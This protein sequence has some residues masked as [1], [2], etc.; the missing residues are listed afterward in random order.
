MPHVS[1]A[2]L[3]DSRQRDLY[4]AKRLAG[5][6]LRAR[7]AD[8][9]S[10]ATGLMTGQARTV[11]R[12][13]TPRDPARPIVVYAGIL[14]EPYDFLRDP[15]VRVVSGFFGPVERMA[16]AAGLAV[17]FFPADFHGFEQLTLATLRPRAIA[18]LMSAPDAEGFCTFGL[19]AGATARPFL[20]AARDPTRLAIAE[21]NADVPRV[22]GLPEFGGNRVHLSEIDVIV[23]DTMPL[24]TV[25]YAEPVAEER[26]IAGFVGELVEAGAT[27]QFGIGGIPNAVA[28]LLCAAPAGDYGIHTEM[29]VDGIMR[30]H[31]AGK[32]VNRKG[33]LDGWSLCTFA[34]GG[35]ELYRW[36]DRNPVVRMVPVSVT[37]DPAHMALNRRFTSINAALA[38]DLH[39]QVV[40]DS[41]AGRQYSGIG[42]HE[43]FTMGARQAPGGKSIVCLRSTVTIAGERRSTIVAEHPAGTLVTTPRHQVDYVVTEWG[44]AHLAV[45]G[46][47]ARAAALTAIAHPDFRANLAHYRS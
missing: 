33:Y 14:A 27:L 40:A 22:A 5:E 12:A 30:L 1:A 2:A 42:G 31:Q 8:V 9:E 6:D 37:N 34:G 35:A 47:G 17:E 36:L 26:A 45:L 24:V 16:R 20:E 25:P 21:V 29:M 38:I 32:V 23:E 4:A 13:L 19:H 11:L 46:D 15:A 18:A 28:E 7:L 39:G 44:I 41:I 43:T 3:G 10:L